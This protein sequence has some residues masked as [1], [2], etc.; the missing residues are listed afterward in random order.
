M[1]E[2]LDI[3]SIGE[4]LIE[5]SSDK[6]LTYAEQLTKY[7]GGDTLCTAVAAAR[8]GSKVGYISRVGNDYFKEFL[9]D[10]WQLEGLDISQVKLVDGFNG[11]YFIARPKDG[12]KE[13]A[14]YRKKTAATKLSIEDISED[15]IKSAQCL[16]TSGAT[17]SLSLSTKEAVKKAYKIAKEN[18]KLTAYD[19]NFD[20]K[21]WSEEEAKEAF[22]EVQDYIDIIFLNM[23]QDGKVFDLDSQDKIIKYFWDKSISTVVVKSPEDFGYYIGSEGDITFVEF[24]SREVIDSTCSGDAFNGAFLHGYMR[25][26]SPIEATRLGSVVAGLQCLGIGAIKSIPH[27]EQV[28]AVYHV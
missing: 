16:Y 4:S 3:I 12:N 23:K 27:K 24:W 28:D 26:M 22:E 7:Y 5:L 2:R 6:S 19:P 25:G 10:S 17:Q 13:F 15:Y 21:L 18:D 9:L 8:L 11:T 14:Y 1:D 20:S